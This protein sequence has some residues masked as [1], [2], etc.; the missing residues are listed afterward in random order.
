MDENN[1]PCV[2]C[3]GI[4]FELISGFYH[5]SECQFV[6]EDIIDHAVEE[7][8]EKLQGIT[9]IKT[10]V[11][12]EKQQL[13]KLK[14]T[15]W[16][17]Y[18]YVIKGLIE[19]LLIL[20]ADMLLRSVVKK[21]WFRYL[22]QLEV[23][24]SERPKLQ[25]VNTSI[26]A[27]IVYGK[28]AKRKRKK[29]SRSGNADSCTQVDSESARAHSR[30]KKRLFNSQHNDTLSK[31]VDNSL[32]DVTVEG[33]KSESHKSSQS[34]FTLKF[35]KYAK[36]E[37]KRRQSKQHIRRHSVDFDNDLTCHRNSY[38][39]ASKKYQN[40]SSLLSINK[41]YSLLYL[42]LLLTKSKIQLADMLRFIREGHLSFNNFK[43][44]FPEELNDNFLTQACVRKSFLTSIGLRESTYQMAQFLNVLD[45]IEVQNLALLIERFCNELNLPRQIER[46]TL[47]SLVNTLPR[48]KI[49]EKT[50]PNYEA[51]ALSL[52]LFQIK[53]LFSL[54]GKTEKYLTNCA[55]G[56]NNR[57]AELNMF[58]FMKWLQYIDYRKNVM[59]KCHF[60]TEFAFDNQIKNSDNFVKFLISKN[61]EYET[62]HLSRK[63]N[64]MGQN[65]RQLLMKLR[66]QQ[67]D[68]EEYNYFEPSFTPFKNYT[69]ELLG[70]RSINGEVEIGILTLNFD[71]CNLDFVL[72]P[73]EYIHLLTGDGN[74][75]VKL[76]GANK[77]IK[78]HKIINIESER[79]KKLRDDRKFSVVRIGTTSRDTLDEHKT[80]EN[81]SDSSE[82]YIRKYEDYHRISARINEIETKMNLSNS[83]KDGKK[84]FVHLVPHE[85]Y[86]VNTHCNLGIL[87]KEVFDE[88]FCSYPYN[89]QLILKELARIGEQSEQELLEEFS[90]TEIYL[91]YKETNNTIGNENFDTIYNDSLMKKIVKKAIKH[92]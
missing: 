20:G 36:T 69:K 63:A 18:N 28:N 26:D 53:L 76:E 21:L 77:N 74:I 60:P 15:T 42:G 92:W 17:C 62:D 72:K 41:I 1:Q 9:N 38:T 67:Q 33:L 4:N 10:T 71:D 54:D 57:K 56:L 39:E 52:I 75:E 85:R 25:A 51:R 22:F 37:L 29:K 27:Q 13:G 66:N 90:R 43:H 34:S 64:V 58:D 16:E 82:D 35:N 86:W 23:I 70:N 83:K 6:R 48:M 2:V 65:C 84:S 31:S 87:S 44:F 40:S 81:F 80:F 73:L 50:I 46:R 68:I 12:R 89:F 19:E 49:I 24:N 79:T 47:S 61:L 78:Q 59:K 3:G 45:F 5:C 14:L 30:K 32:M 11:K 8:D 88:H 55:K 7:F 91:L